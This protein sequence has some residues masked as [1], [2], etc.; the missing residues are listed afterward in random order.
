MQDY[1]C[2]LLIFFDSRS[3]F[4]REMLV[5]RVSVDLKDTTERL[6]IVLKP[7]PVYSV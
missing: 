1:R 5:I 2:K 6:N 7:E 3:W 4:G